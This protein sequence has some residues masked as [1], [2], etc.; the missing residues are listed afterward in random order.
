MFMIESIGHIKEILLSKFYY[1][2]VFRMLLN[3]TI[4]IESRKRNI[5][6]K[7]KAD[8]EKALQS[9]NPPYRRF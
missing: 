3:D 6:P 4:G 2:H 7:Q 1:N 5:F 8:V 9:Q